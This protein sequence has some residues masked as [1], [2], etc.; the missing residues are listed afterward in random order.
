MNAHGAQHRF[1]SGIADRDSETATQPQCPN[2]ERNEKQCEDRCVERQDLHICSRLVKQC[3]FQP[4]EMNGVFGSEL[5]H[6]TQLN[7]QAVSERVIDIT[8]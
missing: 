6:A 2:A 1:A 3:T 4:E 7:S 5:L 8:S